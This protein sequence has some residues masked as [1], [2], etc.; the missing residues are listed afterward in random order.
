MAKAKGEIEIEEALCRSCGYCVKFC[1]KSCLEIKSK[2]S[3]SGH[4]VPEVIA[5]EK[6]IGCAVCADMCPEFAIWVYKL[7][8]EKAS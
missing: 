1:T 5:P 8:E 7:K 2:I 4:L 6:C 3:E